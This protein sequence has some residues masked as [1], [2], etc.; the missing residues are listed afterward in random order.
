LLLEAKRDT[1]NFVIYKDGTIK[2]FETLVLKTSVVSLPFL[3][4][5]RRIKI[6]KEEI[7]AYQTEDYY[8]I[9]QISYS[10][11]AHSKIATE[12]LPGFAVR[13]ATGKLNVYERLCSH[14]N[15]CK[16]DFFIQVGSNGAVF[17]YS[18]ELMNSV[19]KYHYDAYNFFNYK[20][21][22]SLKE[23]IYTAADLYNNA[24][25]FSKK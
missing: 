16:R 10:R 23:R 3:L 13:I 19:L 12:C 21:K 18:P 14:S 20:R 5:D 1:G 11:S 22:V 6:Y 7:I 8:A 24:E 25:S 9:S 4:G 15:T 17:D 2:Y